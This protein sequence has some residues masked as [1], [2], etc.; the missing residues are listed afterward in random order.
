MN[1]RKPCAIRSGAAKR[2][3]ARGSSR[4]SCRFRVTSASDRSGA[5]RRRLPIG[6][7]GHPGL[8][9]RRA[10]LA[11][12]PRP[13]LNVRLSGVPRGLRAAQT[14][15]GTG[16]SPIGY[17][18]SRR[19]TF[20][21]SGF[22]LAHARSASRWPQRVP[23]G[24]AQGPARAIRSTR[25]RTGLR[26]SAPMARPAGR[27]RGDRRRGSRARARLRRCRAARRRRTTSSSRK[28]DAAQSV[29]DLAKTIRRFEHET[30]SD[31]PNIAPSST[32]PPTVWSSSAPRSSGAASREFY[33][34][35]RSLRPAGARGG[36][37]GRPSWPVSSSPASSSRRACRPKRRT[38][39][40]ATASGPD[41]M[42]Q[43][44]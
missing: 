17:S 24:R 20:A 22:V 30:S 36:G 34:R 25:R 12:L 23:A 11:V 28:G 2:E 1:A 19:P 8:R 5:A 32:A 31:Q 40:P 9:A 33:E 26:T 4:R 10:S 7:T 38:A 21:A 14:V 27:R 37:G 18:A 41:A 6:P 15:A 35:G 13:R 42:A 43:G 39:T 29:H 16:G 44:R 3:A